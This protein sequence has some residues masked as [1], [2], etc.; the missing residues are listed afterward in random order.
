MRDIVRQTARPAAWLLA[1]AVIVL[2]V[3][4]PYLRPVTDTPHGFEHFAA[5]FITG[6]A[7][8]FGYERRPAVVAI[9]LVVFSGAIEILQIFVPQRHARLSDFLIDTLAVCAGVVLTSCTARVLGR[10]SQR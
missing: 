3:V 1:S 10:A 7:F 9:A 4:P 2:S 6:L 5:F 8:G